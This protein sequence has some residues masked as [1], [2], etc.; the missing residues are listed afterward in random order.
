M[1]PNAEAD[2]SGLLQLV[3]D[4]SKIKPGEGAE[5]FQETNPGD[6]ETP[7]KIYSMSPNFIVS[8]GGTAYPI[9]LGAIGPVA[10]NAGT[11]MQFQGGAGGP[12]LNSRVT[13]F[14]FRDSS[15]NDPYQYPNGYGVYNNIQGQTVNPQTGR[16][17]PG[18]DPLAHIPAQ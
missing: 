3:G 11:G 17:I 16:T 1:I 4:V 10:P 6:I 7:P 18:T 2:A 9:P 13:G 12:S 8:P 5:A 14:R 15:P